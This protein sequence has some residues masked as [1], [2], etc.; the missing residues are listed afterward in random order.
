MCCAKVNFKL[1]GFSI[2]A[3][4]KSVTGYIGTFGRGG[5]YED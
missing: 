1:V 2:T 3:T 5:G 4:V